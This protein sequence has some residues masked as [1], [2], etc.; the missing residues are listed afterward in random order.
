[1]KYTITIK[2]EVKES[3]EEEK[4]PRTETVYE[5]TVEM[6]TDTLVKDVIKAVNNLNPLI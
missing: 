5:Q 6:A 2:R 3:Q 4:Y 1:M